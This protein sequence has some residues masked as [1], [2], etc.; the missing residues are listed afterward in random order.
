MSKLQLYNCRVL[1]GGGF[2]E[3]PKIG[4]STYEVQVLRALHGTDAV[5]NF[6]NGG[7]A[8]RD[9]REEMQ[10][11]GEMYGFD[12]VEK[13]FSVSLRNRATIEI[14][15]DDETVEIPTGLDLEMPEEI[16]E[17]E[18]AAGPPRVRGTT[19]PQSE[20]LSEETGGRPIP[21]SKVTPA[22]AGLDG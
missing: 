22:M 21:P 16:A 18:V 10:R 19:A 3:V 6:R 11:L 20:K 17:V 1:V 7:I 13:V 12:T 9:V 5:T 14:E 4:V 8:D 2:T 15:A